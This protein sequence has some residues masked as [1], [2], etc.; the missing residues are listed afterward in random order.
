MRIPQC[1][2]KH[3]KALSD[4]LEIVRRFFSAPRF[5]MTAFAECFRLFSEAGKSVVMLNEAKRS[6]ASP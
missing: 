4:I 3:Y 6:E 1:W 5:R 2:Q